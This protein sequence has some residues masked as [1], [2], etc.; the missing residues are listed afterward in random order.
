MAKSELNRTGL[1]ALV[2]IQTANNLQSPTGSMQT[3]PQE[4]H[5][6]FS[7]VRVAPH[8]GQLLWPG[9]LVL[10]L[11]YSEPAHRYEL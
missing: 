3:F 8:E 4:E 10:Y 6:F 11:V 9:I 1:V 2:S 5:V 7:S